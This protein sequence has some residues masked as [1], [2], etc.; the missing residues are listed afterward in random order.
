MEM[1]R[2]YSD[3]GLPADASEGGFP[4]PKKTNKTV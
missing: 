4:P 2:K 1:V 3:A